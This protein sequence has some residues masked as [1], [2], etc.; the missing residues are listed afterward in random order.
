MDWHWRFAFRILGAYAEYK[1]I[2]LDEIET[3][4]I[5]S[6]RKNVFDLS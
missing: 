4:L 1:E 3:Y 5:E 6:A 2:A